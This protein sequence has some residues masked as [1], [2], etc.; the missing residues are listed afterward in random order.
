[1]K[2][3]GTSVRKNEVCLLDDDVMKVIAFDF[4]LLLCSSLA[5]LEPGEELWRSLCC[6]LNFFEVERMCARGV[7]STLFLFRRE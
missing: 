6:A 2:V 7:N 3:I 4:I 5:I 1:M